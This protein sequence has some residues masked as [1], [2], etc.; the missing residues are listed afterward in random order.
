MTDDVCFPRIKICGLTGPD[1]AAACASLGAA[2]V[3]CVF[4]EGSPRHVTPARARDICAAVSG[5]A[6]AVGVFVNA[7]AE[8]VLET[9]SFCGLAAVQLHGRESPEAVKRLRRE[10]LTV[11][12]ALFAAKPPYFSAGSEYDPSAFLVECGRGALPGGN[13]ET[14]DWGAVRPLGRR[15]PLVLAGG[16]SPNNVGIALAAAEPDAVDVSSGVEAVPGTKDLNKVAAFIAAVRRHQAATDARPPL[17]R[18]F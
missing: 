18:I 16:L 8:K 2:A 13:A 6:A 17:R 1:E 4:F 3:G 7:P 11:I 14:W 10:G 12:K 15:R 5:Q 9:A